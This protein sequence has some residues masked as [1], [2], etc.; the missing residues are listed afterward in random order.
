MAAV[1]PFFNAY[2]LDYSG[3]S[4]LET[5]NFSAPFCIGGSGNSTYE[6]LNARYYYAWYSPF[7]LTYNEYATLYSGLRTYIGGIP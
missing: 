6:T 3:I 4:N 1:S 7:S 5:T 2:N